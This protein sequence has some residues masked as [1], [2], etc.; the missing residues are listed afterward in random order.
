MINL[1][2]ISKPCDGLLYYS[3]EYTRILN[4]REGIPAT[5]VIVTH[6][7]FTEDDYIV[8]LNNKY[9]FVDNIVLNDF[10]EDGLVWVL[11]RSMITLPL[12]IPFP[13]ESLL[14]L[15]ELYSSPMIVTYAENH[16]K[17]E[18]ERALKWFGNKKTYD[19]NDYEVYPNGVGE[20][21]EKT[22]NFGVYKEPINAIQYDSLLMG[23]NEKYYKAALK[24]YTP[25]SAILVYP[26]ERYLLDGINHIYAPCDNLIGRFNRYK[27]T[28][29]HFDPAPRLIQEFKYYGKEVD[30]LR[31]KSI[32]DGGSVY[33]N[34]PIKEPNVEPIRTIYYVE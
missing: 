5:L 10:E 24:E 6:P 17:E 16:P 29:D 20:H 13:D 21:F 7:G 27:Y 28:K 1:V 30:Y 19:I 8:S 2:C 15:K 34:R 26:N 25:D 3:Y 9:T 32:V 23:T 33:I 22:I 31:D 18:Y 11:G 4:D 12:R 14:L